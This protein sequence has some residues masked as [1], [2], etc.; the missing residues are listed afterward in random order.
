M[1]V[2]N[3]WYNNKNTTQRMCATAATPLSLVPTTTSINKALHSFSS[4]SWSGWCVF[5]IIYHIS[6]SSKD[7][8][9]PTPAPHPTLPP[10]SWRRDGYFLSLP[11]TPPSVHC[12]FSTLFI[13]ATKQVYIVAAA[14]PFNIAHF[15]TVQYWDDGLQ[16]NDQ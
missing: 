1:E 7:L 11:P 15:D 16:P 2:T 12:I 14:F 13:V 6:S 9:I 4:L 10:R 3:E 8:F 5:P